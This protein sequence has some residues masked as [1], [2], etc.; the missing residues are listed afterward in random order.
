VCVCVCVCVRV[1]VRACLHASSARMEV[2]THERTRVS[3]KRCRTPEK[4]AAPSGKQPEGQPRR[5]PPS[6]PPSLRCLASAAPREWSVPP[7]QAD[8]LDSMWGTKEFDPYVNKTRQ[9]T[10]QRHCFPHPWL[11][12]AGWLRALMR[13]AAATRWPTCWWASPRPSPSL[14]GGPPPSPHTPRCPL[15][16]CGPLR[17]ACRARHRLAGGGAG[18]NAADS[19]REMGAQHAAARAARGPPRV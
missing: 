1:C 13:V 14:P 15:A 8:W 19:P 5:R 7:P 16:G 11:T 2:C 4:Q 6:C 3:T 10:P 18:P 9:A 17:G 12:M